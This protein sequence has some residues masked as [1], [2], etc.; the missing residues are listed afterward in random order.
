MSG[1]PNARM[2]DRCL[3]SDAW[4][5]IDLAS[6]TSQLAGVLAGFTL[7]AIAA[8]LAMP[9]MK[10]TTQFVKRSSVVSSIGDTLAL[11]GTGAIILAVDAYLFAWLAATKPPGLITQPPEDDNS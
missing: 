6:P 7:V 8:L 10:K 5:I 9:S 2:G 4:N 11:L 3:S 1:F